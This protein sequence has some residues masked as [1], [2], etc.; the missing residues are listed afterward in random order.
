MKLTETS[1][2][3]IK[4]IEKEIEKT[5]DDI[6]EAKQNG[7]TELLKNRKEE[8]KEYYGHLKTLE[9]MLDLTKPETR[10]FPFTPE[11]WKNVMKNYERT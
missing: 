9:I 5:L 6:W 10:Y 3:C 11:E 8:L 7:W 1:S 4:L 2:F